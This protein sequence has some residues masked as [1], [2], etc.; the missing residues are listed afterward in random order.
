MVTV[1]GEFEEPPL[2]A[3][4]T[5]IKIAISATAAEIP[6]IA[7]NLLFITGSLLIDRFIIPLIPATPKLSPGFKNVYFTKIVPV[8]PAC[9]LQR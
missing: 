2:Q 6:K 3:V 9:I 7:L 1:F 8:I 4:G 5:T